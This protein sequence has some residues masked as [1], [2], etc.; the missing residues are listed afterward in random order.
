MER[1]PEQAPNSPKW[2]SACPNPKGHKNRIGRDPLKQPVAL[3]HCYRFAKPDQRQQHRKN[4][5]TEK[6]AATLGRPVGELGYSTT[7]SLPVLALGAA[8]RQGITCPRGKEDV[9]AVEG[10][11]IEF[12]VHD[13]FAAVFAGKR[14]ADFGEV[15]FVVFACGGDTNIVIFMGHRKVLPCFDGKLKSLGES[16]GVTL[17]I[18]FRAELALAKGN[19]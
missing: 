13:G 18:V 1:G 17:K 14:R 8:G 16:R 2:R 11:G 5:A 6:R 15:G 3:K 10:M 19:F 9:F 4:A 7:S 12:D